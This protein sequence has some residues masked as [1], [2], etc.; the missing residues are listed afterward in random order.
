MPLL[1][2]VA[3]DDPGIPLAIY[4]YLELSGY[5]VITAKDG[6]ETLSL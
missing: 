2:L 5:S 6:E 1:I 4:D 3:D